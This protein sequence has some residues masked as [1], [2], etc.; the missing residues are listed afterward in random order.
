MFPLKFAEPAEQR[1]WKIENAI[2]VRTHQWESLYIV[3][4]FFGSEVGNDQLLLGAGVGI[5]KKTI[6]VF[7][8][9]ESELHH[10]AE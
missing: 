6:Q 10:F 1:K 8:L 2:E 5:M 9:S 7:S 3:S 4:I